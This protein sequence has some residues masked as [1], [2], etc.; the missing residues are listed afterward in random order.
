M[1]LNELWGQWSAKQFR[2]QDGNELGYYKE[3]ALIFKHINQSSSK[4]FETKNIVVG[5]EERKELFL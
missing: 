4:D 2:A 5:S 1:Y 3:D